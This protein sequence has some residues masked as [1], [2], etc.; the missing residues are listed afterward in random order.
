MTES[1][2]HGIQNTTK[3][4]TDMDSETPRGSML[5]GGR[6]I[7]RVR[8]VMFS[9]YGLP[10]SRCECYSGSTE[11]LYGTGRSP[12]RVLWLKLGDLKATH[13][14]WGAWAFGWLGVVR[15]VKLGILVKMSRRVERVAA[16]SEVFRSWAPPFGL[17]PRMV[18]FPSLLTGEGH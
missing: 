3:R 12:E 10:E 11:V 9:G 18:Q 15:D 6:A 7:G 17:G 14:L 8:L 13:N 5:I 2:Y 4:T 16:F 1:L